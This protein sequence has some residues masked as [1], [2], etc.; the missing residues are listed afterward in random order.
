V[1]YSDILQ[2]IGHTPLVELSRLSP[3]P[4]VRILAKLEGQN[5]SGS[6]KDRIALE[7]VED[8]ERRGELKPGA[9]IL[10]ASSG[11]TGIALA[12]VGRIK[13]YGV[14]VVIPEN[15]SVE[16]RQLL[17]LFGAEVVLSDGSKGSNGAIDRAWELAK[18][19]TY[20]MP[21]QYGNAAN[22][23]AHYRTTGQEIV[24]DAPDVD[25]FVAGLGTGGT[26]M[27]VGRRLKEHNPKV[28]V[29]A[30]EPEQGDLVQGLRS[31]EDG[32]IPPI[33]DLD[34]LDGK[35]MCNSADALR[36]E[37]L[38]AMSEGIF[39]G[40]SSGGVIYGAMRVAQ[41]LEQGTIVALL[42]DGGWKYLS[43]GLWAKAPETFSEDMASKLWW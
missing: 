22:P 10:E 5:P 18:E 3:N 41:R 43:T 14:K 2:A 9:T 39:A 13:G 23:R 36:G 33:L 16:R 15:V 32:F 34:L 40:I 24:D 21:Y 35:I 42:A 29:I 7:M 37:R 27:G 30:V 12:M 8:G 31:L 11:N 19:G 1:V 4:R 28:R 6:L 17:E 25:V 26:L 38:L 20:Y